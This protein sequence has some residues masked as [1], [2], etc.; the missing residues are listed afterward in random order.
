M[1]PWTRKVDPPRR[2]RP[3]PS[4]DSSHMGWAGD[5]LTKARVEEG[6][7]REEFDYNPECKFGRT[8][9]RVRLRVGW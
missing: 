1:G 7:A 2:R 8:R 4:H 9:P 3:K 5:K 6:L